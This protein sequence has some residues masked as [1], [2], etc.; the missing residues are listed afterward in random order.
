MLCG[1]CDENLGKCACPDKR[2]RLEELA[3][4][5]FLVLPFCPHCQELAY[6]C[7]CEPK[8]GFVVL[9]R[10]GETLCWMSLGVL[11]AREKEFRED[12]D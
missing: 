7:A 3:K 1:N 12:R 8:A 4:S 11:P 9:K 10:A 6:L 5:D 2:E